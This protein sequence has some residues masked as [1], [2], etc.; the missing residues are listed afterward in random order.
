MAIKKLLT[1][2]SVISAVVLAIY[3]WHAEPRRLSPNPLESA[4]PQKMQV[5]SVVP[6]TAPSQAATL[7]DSARLQFP[8]PETLKHEAGDD[9]HATPPS[10]IRFAQEISSRIESAKQSPDAA[11][12]LFDRFENE[13]VGAQVAIPAQTLCLN[14]AEELAQKYPEELK[15]RYERLQASAPERVKQLQGALEKL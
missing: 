5:V 9:L 6:V 2:A 3:F 11:K 15:D 4:A 12:A 14:G 7:G 10:L 13:C 1:F 8:D